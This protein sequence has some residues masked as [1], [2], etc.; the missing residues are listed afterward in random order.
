MNWEQ[1][2]TTIIAVCSS[3]VGSAALAFIAY[4]I[5]DAIVHKI[6]SKKSKLLASDKK[7][8]AD[9][10][11][12]SLQNGVEVDITSELDKATKKL[13]SEFKD[14]LNELIDS[15]NK[16][17]KLL[18][19]T[20]Q[21]LAQFKSIQGTQALAVLKDELG[22]V[23]EKELAPLD[24]DRVVAKLKVVEEEKVDEVKATVKY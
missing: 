21:T 18:Y 10:I 24:N 9:E 13:V 4:I 11:K 2:Q 14:T 22:K 6:D 16:D 7:E 20:A 8:I 1:I 23:D 5:K 15:E 12:A 3:T 19:A 17:R